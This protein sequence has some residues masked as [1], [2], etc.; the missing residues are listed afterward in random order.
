MENFFYQE[1]FPKNKSD[2]TQYRLVTDQ[3]V[4]VSTFQDQEMVVV[5]ENGLSLLAAEAFRDISF[6]YRTAHLQSLSHIAADTNTSVN[7]RFVATEM[8]KNAAISSEFIFP[9]CQDTG[10]AI[11]I[12]KKGQQVWTGF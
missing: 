2:D 7:D 12:G 3:Y 11:V 6:L 5:K 8:L 10:T 9:M 4:S 1:M